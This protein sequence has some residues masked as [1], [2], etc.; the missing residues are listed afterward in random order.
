[1]KLI[2]AILALVLPVIPAQA[3]GELD[4]EDQ[5]TNQRRM[6][7]NLPQTLVVRVNKIDGSVAVLHSKEALSEATDLSAAKFVEMKNTD[8]M[9]ELDGDSSASGW[10]FY[11]YNYNY[12]YPTYNYYGYQYY[13]QNYYSYAYANYYYYWYRWNW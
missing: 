7:E 3:E 6:A 10:Y 1:M 13:Y 5:I 8:A 4:N 9:N 2:L 11:W 12:A